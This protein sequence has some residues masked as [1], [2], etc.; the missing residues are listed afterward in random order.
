MNVYILSARTEVRS[1][2]HDGP[3]IMTTS[4]EPITTEEV[5]DWFRSATSARYPKV[6]LAEHVWLLVRTVNELRHYKNNKRTLKIIETPVDEL[7]D[8]DALTELADVENA[9]AAQHTLRNL[10]KQLPI[11]IEIYQRK[12]LDA[13]VTLRLRQLLAALTELREDASVLFELPGPGGQEGHWHI[14]AHMLRGPIEFAWKQ[15][16]RSQLSNKP[17]G[18]L[19]K[20]LSHAVKAVYGRQVSRHTI[21][22]EL[23]RDKRRMTVHEFS[24]LV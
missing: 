12:I 5:L 18:P 10:H 23:K 8:L 16:G 4:E 24:K 7:T 1:R 21:S 14:Q 20:V 6:P 17:A 13:R 15:A 19:V 3:C 9:L 2:R 11:L 22:T